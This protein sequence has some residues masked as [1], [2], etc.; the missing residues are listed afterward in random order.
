MHRRELACHFPF[1][2]LQAA[3]LHPFGCF[4]FGFIGG[5]AIDRF[6]GWVVAMRLDAIRDQDVIRRAALTRLSIPC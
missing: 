6:L 5:L 2:G 1:L 3:Q 4:G